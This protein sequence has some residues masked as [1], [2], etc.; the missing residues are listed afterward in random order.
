MQ[1]NKYSISFFE[2]RY[3]DEKDPRVLNRLQMLMHLREGYTQRDVSQI[4]HVSVGIVPYWK[5]RFEQEGFEGLKDKKGRGKKPLLTKKQL[6]RITKEID[7]GLQMG[8]G[9][10]RG[11]KTKDVKSFILEEYTV[12]YTPR[13]CNRLL[14]ALH[15]RLKVP[16][17][18]HKRRN[19][20][21][22]GAFKRQLKKKEKYWARE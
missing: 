4:H 5:K 8:D 3:S 20:G 11:Y 19:Q 13:H 14:R 9:Y 17:P 1:L 18:R 21:A 22:V 7:K 15:Y 6:I 10:R 12:D 16:R 2:E